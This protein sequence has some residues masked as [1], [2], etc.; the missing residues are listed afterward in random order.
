MQRQKI[1]KKK[2]KTQ[3]HSTDGWLGIDR[4][5]TNKLNALQEEKLI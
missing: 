4:D 2:K 5:E 1:E 3:T